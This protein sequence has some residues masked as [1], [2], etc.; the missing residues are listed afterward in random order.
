MAASIAAEAVLPSNGILAQYAARGTLRGDLGQPFF[1]QDPRW[2]GHPGKGR[3]I[4][5]AGMGYPGRFGEAELTVAARELCWSLGRMGKRHL[6]SVLIGGGVGNMSIKI[7]VS[8]W[9][10]GVRQALIGS[11]RTPNII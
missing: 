2:T 10:R 6:A 8:A 11:H 5:I 4:A 1:L 7:A 9:L 3:V